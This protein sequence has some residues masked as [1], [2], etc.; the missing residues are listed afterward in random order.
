MALD[1][2]VYVEDPGAANLTIG[3]PDVMQ[4]HG[5]RALI[6]AD[7]AARDYLSAIGQ[8]F[9][10]YPGSTKIFNEMQP[11]ALAIGTS[12]QPASP[13]RRLLAE[14]RRQGIPS[15]GLI[16][17]PVNA[18]LRF[19]VHDGH[20][21][22]PDH[23]I[24]AD[25]LS[26]RAFLDIGFVDARIHVA[27]NPRLEQA[28]RKGRELSEHSRSALRQ[29]VVGSISRPLIVFLSELSTG[30]N[31][32]EFLRSNDYS[33]RGRHQAVARTFIVLE[34]ILD[35]VSDM[36]PRPAVVLR[37]HPKDSIENYTNYID[38]ITAVSQGDDALDICLCSD[39]VIGMTTSL[40]AECRHAGQ[41]VLSVLP[42][43]AEQAWLADIAEGKIPVVTQRVDI[44]PAIH[45][46]LSGPRGEPTHA[47][48][49]SIPELMLHLL[50]DFTGAAR[51]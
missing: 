4:R 7:G 8:E 5:L 13:A 28:R 22:F 19:A 14:A 9:I 33:L 39:L 15:V 36:V 17:A 12:E 31:P 40:L 34:E 11:A 48:R 30:L 49:V 47:T 41:R 16:D 38:E 35:V 21:E 6:Y 26:R 18:A 29:T 45:T 10:D 27:E 44:A 20:P 1:L 46:L 23:L 51:N 37:L 50:S 43:E 24:V 42:R 3:V 2:M 32:A 25:E